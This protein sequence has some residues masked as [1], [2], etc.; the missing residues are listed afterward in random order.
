MY[1]ALSARVGL[2]IGLLFKA[3]HPLCPLQA[4]VV[5]PHLHYV[6]GHVFAREQLPVRALHQNFYMWLSVAYL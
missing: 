1:I 5:N 4:W 6:G 3:V 2:Y